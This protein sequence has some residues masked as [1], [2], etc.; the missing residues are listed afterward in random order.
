MPHFKIKLAGIYKISH[1]SGYYYI[2]QSSDI[3]QR[4]GGHYTDIIL[5]T[6]SST[7]LS[8]L[9][10]ST[11]PE[12]WTFQILETVSRTEFKKGIKQ[13]P[14]QQLKMCEKSIDYLFRK[15]LLRIEKEWMQKFSKKFALNKDNKHFS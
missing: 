4:W 5:R 8:K 13:D 11:R 1:S 2:G 15:E 12:E 6:H 7:A 9:F 10:I 3:F 14:E